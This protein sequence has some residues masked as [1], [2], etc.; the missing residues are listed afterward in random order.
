[1]SGSSL[2]RWIGRGWSNYRQCDWD[3]PHSLSS[4]IWNVLGWVWQQ[5]EWFLFLSLDLFFSSVCTAGAESLTIYE[6]MSVGCWRLLVYSV[7]PLLL[8]CGCWCLKAVGG[9]VIC[10][11]CQV[12]VIYFPTSIFLQRI[13]KR[14][15]LYV[16]IS[17]LGSD[18]NL[19]EKHVVFLFRTFW[20]THMLS[21]Y[22]SSKLAP[23]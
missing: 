4:D 11:F 20:I 15:E 21:I 22:G 9:G 8:A 12:F 13:K 2:H 23:L 19:V 10:W 6:C 3:V 16:Y 7:F 17:W 5:G 18:P 14:S 1:M